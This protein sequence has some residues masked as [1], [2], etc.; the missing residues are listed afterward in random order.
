MM[1]KYGDIQEV[2]SVRYTNASGE[3]ITEDQIHFVRA[4]PVDLMDLLGLL[5]DRGIKV[6]VGY[7]PN[8]QPR[9]FPPDRLT[10]RTS[11]DTWM[12]VEVPLDIPIV[13]CATFL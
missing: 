13:P 11:A 1:E 9:V 12:D 4:L 3:A 10:V 8:Y 2:L 7:P 6:S 5:A